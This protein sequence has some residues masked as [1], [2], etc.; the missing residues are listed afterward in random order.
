M[1]KE[2]LKEAEKDPENPQEVIKRFEKAWTKL[3]NQKKLSDQLNKIR[4]LVRLGVPDVLKQPVW[5]ELRHYFDPG[6]SSPKAVYM[7]TK[8]NVHKDRRFHAQFL[9][10]SKCCENNEPV[11]KVTPK[12]K[13]LNVA[14]DEDEEF[15]VG[16]ETKRGKKSLASSSSGGTE[17]ERSW[18]LDVTG[19]YLTE[20]G[21]RAA[22]NVLYF[23]SYEHPEIANTPFISAV[24][25]IMMT[26]THAEENCYAVIES[27][28]AYSGKVEILK[29]FFF[30]NS[31][32]FNTF[33]KYL[34]AYLSLKFPKPY[35]KVSNLC[36][37]IPV[38][39]VLM[40]WLVNFFVGVLPFPLVL[41]IFD[42]FLTEGCEVF[43]RFLAAMFSVVPSD[44]VLTVSS[45]GEFRAYLARESTKIP[46]EKLAKKA[47]RFR[48]NKLK[49]IQ[50]S[51]RITSYFKAKSKSKRFKSDDYD[52]D[53]DDDDDDFYGGRSRSRGRGRGSDNDSDN[54]DDD[55]SLDEDENEE[56]AMEL[57]IEIEKEREQRRLIEELYYTPIMEKP[58]EIFTKK[59]LSKLW[60]F[61][62][63][64]LA[65]TDPCLLYT[66]SR[67]GF[68]IT[69]MINATQ[70]NFPF[71]LV[72]QAGEYVFGM[73][74]PDSLYDVKNNVSFG[75]GE[76]FLW[77]LRPEAEKYSWTN[78]S[79]VFMVLMDNSHTLT[80]GSGGCGPGLVI[81]DD[82]HV[83]SQSCATFGN[84]PLIGP[85]GMKDE[86]PCTHVEL[87]G[88]E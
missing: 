61:L 86:I 88:F 12:N 3:M 59:E 70:H 58:S 83:Q 17:P 44:G 28:L 22:Q 4:Y 71:L 51:A 65:I 47:F 37:G 10:S 33:L 72:M 25:M 11:I 45:P 66:A 68:N 60:S 42:T 30:H 64:R 43:L 77:S 7:L 34:D 54:D 80:V 1:D 35:K 31:V 57:E 79:S 46:S 67:D 38:S 18:K 63:H 69:T 16:S 14:N 41:R 2:K 13:P 9:Q 84:I 23:L 40:P 32:D 20:E 36:G 53:D 15:E 78:E 55:D 75:N 29:K 6:V 81:S 76:C 48:I 82:F 56:L 24:V 52:D 62:P 85:K 27:L 74:S 19:H 5:I 50:E 73:Y 26:F 21:I 87:Y 39:E 49:L 8:Q